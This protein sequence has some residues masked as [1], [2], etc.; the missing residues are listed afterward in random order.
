M[1]DV[2]TGLLRGVPLYRP[3]MHILQPY[4][5]Y[6]KN[7]WLVHETSMFLTARVSS[8]SIKV[9]ENLRNEQHSI[10]HWLTV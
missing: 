4:F 10:I 8:E 7:T 5:L 1:G 6:P 2:Q 9:S 3:N